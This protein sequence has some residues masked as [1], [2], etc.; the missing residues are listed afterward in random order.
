MTVNDIVKKARRAL[1]DTDATGWDDATLIDIVDHAQKDFCFSARVYLRTLHLG[2]RDNIKIYKLPDDCFQ[3]DR[4]EYCNKALA[5]LSR[6]DQDT[7][8]VAKGLHIIKSNIDMGSIEIS[9]PFE[10]LD[11]YARFIPGE[12]VNYELDSHLGVVTSITGGTVIPE[13]G[14]TTVAQL[15]LPEYDDAMYGDI[16][17]VINTELIPVR[18]ALGVATTTHIS[19]AKVLYGFLTSVDANQAVGTY[20]VCTDVL[21]KS[22]YLK[23]YYSALPSTVN[24]LYDALVVSNM[25]AKALVHYTVATAR[26][27]DNDEGNYQIGDAEMKRY[28]AEVKKAK[29]L[30]AKPY[31]TSLGEARLTQYRRL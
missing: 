13:F 12:E 14:V 7:R 9:E 10:C 18:P 24:S 15:V 1:G 31:S 6:E 2:L 29:V 22:N 3:V 28:F 27:S 11:N 25:W 20:G 21:V 5:V 26:Q 23:V 30:S 16:G 4:V 17:D 8:Y 19:N